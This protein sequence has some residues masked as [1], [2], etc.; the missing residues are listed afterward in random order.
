VRRAI[1]PAGQPT[2][3]VGLAPLSDSTY[4]QLGKA[5]RELFEHYTQLPAP[6]EEEA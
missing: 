6:T 4:E 3:L 2:Q 5:M 1:D